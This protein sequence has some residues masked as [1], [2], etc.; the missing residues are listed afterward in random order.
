MSGP[1]N[2]ERTPPI[3][4]RIRLVKLPFTA[5]FLTEKR[6]QDGRGM[7]HLILNGREF[8]RLCYLT[9]LPETGYRGGHFHKVKT[10]GLYVVQGR[11][12]VDFVCS[13]SGERLS[14]ELRVGDRLEV[15]PGIAH[16]I[17]A[18]SPLAFL[19]YADRPYE[20]EDDLRFEF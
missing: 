7:A 8:K 12:L 11:A 9:L 6:Y 4:E 3:K 14:L 17:K 2:K 13:E 19:E 18:L 15:P 16:R 5:E 10:E 20:A 1:G